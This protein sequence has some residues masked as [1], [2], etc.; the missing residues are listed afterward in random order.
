VGQA[1]LDIEEG[2]TA[3]QAS[4]RSR[5][6]GSVRRSEELEEEDEASDE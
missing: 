2:D 1:Y 5:S 6:V 3:Y 4:S